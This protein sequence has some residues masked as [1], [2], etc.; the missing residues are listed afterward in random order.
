MEEHAALS[1]ERQASICRLFSNATRIQILWVLASRTRTVSEIAE[2]VQASLPTTSRH[3]RYMRE[4]GILEAKRKG[5]EIHYGIARPDLVNL[6][7]SRT[8]SSMRP[9]DG[10]HVKTDR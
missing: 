1:A 10:G 9:K 5:K 2:E 7:L 8:P 4:E 6:L 3:L